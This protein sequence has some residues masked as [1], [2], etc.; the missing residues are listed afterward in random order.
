MEVLQREDRARLLTSL[1]FLALPFATALD[2]SCF[3]FQ[4]IFLPKD[5]SSFRISLTILNIFHVRLKMLLTIVVVSFFAGVAFAVWRL[6]QNA[7]KD[8]LPPGTKKLPG[9]KGN[10][11]DQM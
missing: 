11:L 10:M 4:L 6:S 5:F 9:P 7:G 2:H 1:S 8:G 3:Y